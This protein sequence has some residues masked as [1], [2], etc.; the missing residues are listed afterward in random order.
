MLWLLPSIIA[1]EEPGA[2]KALG[3]R[4]ETIDAACGT[5]LVAVPGDRITDG[6]CTEPFCYVPC[7]PKMKTFLGKPTLRCCGQW[8]RGLAV[9]SDDQAKGAALVDRHV[10]LLMPSSLCGMFFYTN[11]SSLSH[12][13]LS[14]VVSGFKKDSHDRWPGQYPIG[15]NLPAGVVRPNCMTV[16]SAAGWLSMMDLVGLSS[17]AE[18]FDSTVAGALFT[19]GPPWLFTPSVA[20]KNGYY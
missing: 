7:T 3:Y 18:L 20:D 16:C 8:S 6:W 14:R 5:F 12:A 10:G 15:V 4:R 2:V 17:T 13:Q 9:R 1:S 19:L 11:P